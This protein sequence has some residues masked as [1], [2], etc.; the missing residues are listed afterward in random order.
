MLQSICLSIA[1]NL[2]TG[3]PTTLWKQLSIRAQAEGASGGPL[4][5]KGEIVCDLR[6]A[7]F[8]ARQEGYRPYPAAGLPPSGRL[9]LES[10]TFTKTVS[11]SF[12]PGRARA[13]R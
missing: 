12:L 4:F 1:H 2:S 6:A 10:V 13:A 7:G 5:Q 11:Y 9:E 3:S 8:L